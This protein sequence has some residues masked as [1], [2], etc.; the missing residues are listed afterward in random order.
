MLRIGGQ[1]I[2]SSTLMLV[3]LES[4][5]V[6]SSLVLV[7]LL[8]TYGLHVVWHNIYEWA[9]F[10]HLVFNTV[11]VVLCFYYHDLYDLRI[12]KPLADLSIKLTRAVGVSL[13]VIAFA[14]LIRP[15]LTPRQEVIAAGLPL[16]MALIVAVRAAMQCIRTVHMKHERL[17]L[18]GS[19]LV[20]HK[21]MT[22]LKNRPDFNYDIVGMLTEED[23][24]PAELQL[25]SLGSI[26]E[27]QR[28]A[29]EQRIDRVVVCL[30]EKR[31][32]MPIA[33]LMQLKFQGVIIEDP[34]SLYE[35]VTGR[36]VIENL[37]PSWFIFSGG[38]RTSR[39]RAI[40]KRAADILVATAGMFIT[41]PL[42]LISV[43]CIQAEDG[44]P[45]L[46]RQRRVGLHGRLFSI[47]KLR[48]MR[49]A[50]P[51][52]TP[53][54]TGDRDPR[55][56]RVGKYLRVFRLDEI[57]QFINVLRGDMSL[58][59]PRPEQ[60]YFCTKLEDQIPYFT[61]RHSVRPGITGWAQIKYGYGSTIE[62]A[63]RKV[64]LDLFY[65]KHFS[66]LLDVAIMFETAKV[67]LFGRGR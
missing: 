1:V 39:F 54:W 55:I 27:L 49:N 62:D 15:D 7:S 22:E 6:F 44:G 29:C 59:G 35:R 57:P 14:T 36:I 18:V 32:V 56:T 61:F 9:L 20:G 31:G 2:P 48:S 11:V 47:L 43:M 66:L 40:V 30:R 5:I 19:G 3:G 46:Y 21:L 28:V 58:I 13:L 16:I 65:I 25:R 33:T 10:R 42:L 4:G 17:L 45:V 8:Q 34:Y 12:V 41:A 50:D 60:P 51:G 23:A 53:S 26:G 37:S 24:C 52:E 67:V 64:E 63:W 38:F